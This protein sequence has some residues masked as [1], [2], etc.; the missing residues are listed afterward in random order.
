MSATPMRRE[1]EADVERYR[2]P[3]GWV[4]FVVFAGIMGIVVGSFNVMYGLVALFRD[5]VFVPTR[6]GLLVFDVTA[7][8][9]ITL[10]IGGIQMLVGLALFTGNIWA[11]VMGVVFASLNAI[12]QLGFL[13][14]QPVWSTIIIAVDVLI[15]YS[16]TVHGREVAQKH[17]PG[18]S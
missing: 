8:G 15:I 7:W 11:R 4:G 12:A 10:I 1:A 17:W 6:G 2:E 5:D 14:A 18:R 13:T 9:W 16:L 3:T